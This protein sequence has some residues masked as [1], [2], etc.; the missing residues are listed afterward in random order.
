MEKYE[1]SRK[2]VKNGIENPDS[3]VEGHSDRKIAQK[4]VDNRILRIIFGLL[5]EEEL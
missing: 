4:N 5:E 1:I 3:V 2:M